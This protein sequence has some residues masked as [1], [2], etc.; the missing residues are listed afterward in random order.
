MSGI[1][2]PVKISAGPEQLTHGKGRGGGDCS[3]ATR[4]AILRLFGCSGGGMGRIARVLSP[5]FLLSRTGD[6][7]G[8]SEPGYSFLRCECLVSGLTASMNPEA[9][10][11]FLEYREAKER[12]GDMTAI[13]FHARSNTYYPSNLE[14]GELLWCMVATTSSRFALEFGTGRGFGSLA[15]AHALL[16]VSKECGGAAARLDTLDRIGIDT[17]QIW[18]RRVSEGNGVAADFTRTPQSLRTAWHAIGGAETG[19]V[20]FLTG[21][22][23]RCSPPINGPYDFVF[24]DAG[25]DFLSVWRD[26][27]AIAFAQNDI[28]PKAIVFDDVGGRVGAG[29]AKAIARFLLPWLDAESITVVEMPTNAQEAAEVGYHA[30]LVVDGMSRPDQLMEAL[31]QLRKPHVLAQ[32][33]IA[34]GV[35]SVAR[36]LL[37]LARGFVGGTRRGG[38]GGVAHG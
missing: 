23:R 35:V 18:P 28:A 2:T 24:V 5:P 12:F 16:H 19:I 1:D 36:L 22:S 31:A 34:E 4:A 38:E 13:R 37:R 14:R 9:R 26:L 33:V 3:A 30:M 25:H 17:P 29:V 8:V 7:S 27:T 15:L 32:L 10:E 21:T 11:R 20:R 6:L